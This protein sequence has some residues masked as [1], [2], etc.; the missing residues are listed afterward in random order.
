MIR[1]AAIGVMVAVVGL[2]V[3]VGNDRTV[4]AAPAFSPE[5]VLCRKTLYEGVRQV[6]VNVAR[7]E[8]QCHRARVRNL[9][10]GTDCSTLSNVP[11]AELADLPSN[12]TLVKRA[13]SMCADASPPA[14]L[15]FVTCPAPCDTLP[16]ADYA[17]VGACLACLAADRAGAIVETLYG[18]PPIPQSFDEVSCQNVI[19]GELRYYL[20]R[21]HRQ[22]K[23]C[24]Q[25]HDLGAIA[26]SVDCRTADLT[27]AVAKQ[28]ARADKRLAKRCPDEVVGPLDSCG[29]DVAAEQACFAGAIDANVDELFDVVYQPSLVVTPTATATPEPTL[30]ADATATPEPT[31]TVTA[32]PTATGTD[33]ATPTPTVVDTETPT[34]TPTAS[35]TETP[36]PT[37]SETATPTPTAT[38]TETPTPTPTAT[39]SCG[40][41]S[42]DGSETCD[43]GGT[44][45]GD[46]CS[47]TCI[48]ESGF[49]CTGE[50]SACTPICGNGVDDVGEQCDDGNAA[51]ADGCTFCIVDNGYQCTGTP[52]A[53]SGI[54][55]DGLIRGGEECDDDDTDPGDGCSAL[56]LVESGF[57]CVGEPS[58]CTP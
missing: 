31:A 44:N 3:W 51:A 47:S 37:P 23:L 52:S 15:G 1:R 42:I 58:V 5:D 4:S 10:T 48:V 56:C 14:S 16:I 55:G 40:D 45:D 12:K 7:V 54:C 20:S 9:A 35:D 22:Q 2:A 53:C 33:T 11:N 49:D 28:L 32:D 18:T 30:T 39:P 43:D 36:T 21:R 46:G 38:E 19:A 57:G 25:Q 29:D 13:R 17:N 34:S 8:T 41:G 50:P 24:Q 6:M 26:A 27:G